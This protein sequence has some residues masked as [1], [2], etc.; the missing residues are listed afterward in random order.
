MARPILNTI[1]EL[2]AAARKLATPERVS[3]TPH[4]D[5][6]CSRLLETYE[7]GP[8][9]QQELISEGAYALVGLL[10]EDAGIELPP[11]GWRFADGTPF[12]GCGRA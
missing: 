8:A 7:L 4:L 3:E 1:E 11:F 10:L 2:E 12:P 6:L 9:V 5:E